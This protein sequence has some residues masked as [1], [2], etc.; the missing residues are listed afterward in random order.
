MPETAVPQTDLPGEKTSKTQPF[1]SKPPAYS[2][3]YVAASDVIDF[4]PALHQQALDNLKNYRWEQSPFTPPAHVRP[5]GPQGSVNI[6]NASGGVNWP[7]SA[8]DP[9][10]GIFYT[11]AGNSAVTTGGYSDAQL[12]VV[13]QEGQTA[14]GGRLAIWEDPNGRGARGRGEAAPGA[15]G[16]AAGGARGAAD[17]G[18]GAGRG[19]G[20]GQAAA[21]GGRAGAPGAGAQ[22]GGRGGLTQGLS[23]LPIVKPPYGV[24]A[25]IDVNNGTLLWQKPHGDTPDNVRATLQQMG[26]NYPGKT[27]QGGS[28]GSLVTK[29]LFVVGDPSVTTTPEHPRGAMLRAYD[30]KTGNEV[31]AVLMPAQQSGSPMSYTVGGKQYIIVAV[32]GGASTGEYIAYALPNSMTGN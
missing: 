6:G 29:T 7:G 17:G 2:R 5:G 3:T 1:P 26:I 19:A 14:T 15:R 30:K 12:A 20:A 13:S 27:G 4:T 8:F 21:A 32:S 31:G 18:R 28:V 9:D 23:G 22:G 11:Q 24:V 25:A 16:A 10:T